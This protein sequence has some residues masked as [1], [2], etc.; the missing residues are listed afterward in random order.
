MKIFAYLERIGMMH[1]MIQRQATGTPEECARRLG[2]SRTTL[3]ELI[4]ELKLRGAPISYSKTAKTFYYT[5]PFDVTIICSLKPL[6][7]N[8]EKKTDGGYYYFPA[9]FFS[10]RCRVKFAV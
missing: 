6:T 8:E 5:S 9:F 10:G 3:Y 4:D 7:V 1:R 2:V